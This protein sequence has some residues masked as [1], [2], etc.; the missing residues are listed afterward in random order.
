M[1]RAGGKE[2]REENKTT[3]KETDLAQLGARKIAGSDD[4]EAAVLVDQ[5]AHTGDIAGRELDIRD[6]PHNSGRAET[7]GE[8]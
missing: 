8:R 2:E 6:A 7:N 1:E 3:E 4:E 5:L